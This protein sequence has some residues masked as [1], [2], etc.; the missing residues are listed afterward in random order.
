MSLNYYHLFS[1]FGVLGV[2]PDFT[3]VSQTLHC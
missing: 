3:H 2:E 1:F